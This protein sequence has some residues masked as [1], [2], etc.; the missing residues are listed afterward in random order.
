MIICIG[1]YLLG[2]VVMLGF[3]ST[4]VAGLPK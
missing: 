3:A 4:A 2:I 1:M